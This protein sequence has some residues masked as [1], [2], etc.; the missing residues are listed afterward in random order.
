MGKEQQ[1]HF[2][3]KFM[4]LQLFFV[5]QKNCFRMQEFGNKM[6]RD[7]IMKNKAKYQDKK[8][9]PKKKGAPDQ[10]MD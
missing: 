6:T 7:T 2:N 3:R 10:V 9:L 8:G 4:G 1:H 5:C